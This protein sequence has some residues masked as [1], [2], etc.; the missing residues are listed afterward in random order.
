MT[1]AAGEP[2]TESLRA[3]LEAAGL[4]GAPDGAPVLLAAPG[5]RDFDELGR[6]VADVVGGRTLV[7][8]AGEGP[9]QAALHLTP[10]APELAGE[11]APVQ[12]GLD[13]VALDGVRPVTGVGYVLYRLEGRCVALAGPRGEGWVLYLGAPVPALAV[14]GLAWIR[15][16]QVPARV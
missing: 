4:A 16:R 10:F 5:E 13:P 12:P 8:W 1:E 9:L 11:A 7:T 14:A 3:A 2:A 6:L 15:A